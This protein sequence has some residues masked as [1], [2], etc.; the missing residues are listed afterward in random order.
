V[1]Q[2]IPAVSFASR[3]DFRTNATRGR[4]AQPREVYDA[5]AMSLRLVHDV[6]CDPGQV[7]SKD[8]LLLPDSYRHNMRP[9]LKNRYTVEMAPRFAR[10]L[11]EREPVRLAGTYFHLD[12]ELRGHFG[13]AMTEQVAKLWG[14]TAA[15]EG[16]PGLKVLLALNKGRQLAGW[17]LTLYRAAGIAREDIEFVEGPV[18]VER[19]V[20][21]TQMLS[22]PQYVHP[23]ITDT[24]RR[25]SD[26]LVADAPERDYPDRFFCARRTKKRACHN[27]AEVEALFAEQGFAIVY[28][29]DYSLPEQAAMFRHASVIGGYAGSAL[30]NVLYAT[31]PKHLVMLGSEAYTATNEYMIASVQGH[32]IDLITCRPDLEQPEDHWSRAAFES[33]YTFDPDR[34]G[35]LLR[36][37]FAS[38]R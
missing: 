35:P 15:R 38:L 20:T 18:E 2:T 23:A 34:E 28:P 22:E 21:A 25:L 7:V 16:F 24:W 12:N 32:R 30:F 19:L 33:S 17:E 5:P 27:A 6:R 37:V 1:L 29:E 13:H 9:R 36:E 4:L 8:R 31:E 3:C 10:L 14:W 26:A 11:D